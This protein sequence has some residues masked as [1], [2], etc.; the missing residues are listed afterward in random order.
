METSISIKLVSRHKLLRGGCCR[1]WTQWSLQQP[2]DIIHHS[3][4]PRS[5]SDSNPSSLC[6]NT[7]H[8]SPSEDNHRGT[9]LVLFLLGPSVAPLMPSLLQEGPDSRNVS[10]VAHFLEP[11]VR[12]GS[13]STDRSLSL[14][15]LLVKL[16][17]VPVWQSSEGFT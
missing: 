2:V 4:E 17:Q 8:T 1:L 14:S 10:P 11:P 7:C 12:G 16:G 13:G 3:A 6:F 5:S 9:T 15:R